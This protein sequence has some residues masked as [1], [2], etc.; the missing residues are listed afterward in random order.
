[1]NTK[2]QVL[3]MI[4]DG[5]GYREEPKHNAIAA[6]NPEHMNQLWQTY[7]HALLE[8][9]GEA[10]GLPK[11]NIG[12]SEIGHLTIGAGRTIYTDI[13]K[14]F[15]A[16]EEN[17]LSENKAFQDLFAHVKKHNSTLHIMGLVS[18][19]GV[20]SHQ[21]HLFAFLR[22]AKE[23]GIKKIVIHV[24]T[25]GRDTPPQS[26]SLYVSQLHTVL[27]EIGIG[28]VATVIGRYFA[29]DRDT[30]WDRTQKAVD[31]LFEGKGNINSGKSSEQVVR[32]QYDQNTGDEFISPQILLN[33]EGKPDVIKKDDGV[34]F[35][36]FRPDRARQIT[37]KVLEK[38][39]ELN[40]FFVSLTQYDKTLPTTVAY[41]PE[42]I[43]NVLSD[44][45]AGEG[46]T[47]AHIAETEKY[48]HV[49]Y[50]FN[51]MRETKH[52]YEEQILIDSRK[53]VPTHDLAPEM[54]AKEI[55]DKTIEYIEKGT[56]FIVINIANADMVGHTGKWEPAIQAVKFE[57]EQIGRI[58]K[59]MQEKGG[60]TFI[61]ADHGNAEDMYDEDAGHPR[62]AHSL[63]PVPL[64]VTAKNIIL[65]EKGTLADVAP[66]ILALLNIQKPKEMT[67]NS[68]IAK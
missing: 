39:D 24:F 3:L 25:D 28:H 43:T 22:F 19:G 54:R 40:L 60:V 53:D 41:P 1:M 31:A 56:D 26:A 20:H 11:G 36:N 16:I 47:Q 64:I 61:T 50:F 34:F 8:A 5:W 33:E 2:R 30:N 21:D 9:S 51:G 27:E 6:A 15:K 35:F 17:K 67:G 13:V 46:M 10:I 42:T 37:T 68:L 38:K 18:P 44:V 29:M 45:F 4:L 58:T 12:T 66:T 23:S 65:K 59:A 48:A 63:Y 52:E 14:V 62:T 49:T 57:D 55:A 7:P 32:E